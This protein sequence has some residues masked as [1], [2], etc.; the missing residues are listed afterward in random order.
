[1]AIPELGKAAAQARAVQDQPIPPE[2][3]AIIEVDTAFLVYRLPTG[4]VVANTDINAPI[5]P[6]RTAHSHDII[7][8]SHSVIG[9][10]ETMARAPYIGRAVVAEQMQMAQQIQAQRQQAAAMSALAGQQREGGR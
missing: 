5:V 7:G 8:M 10:V 1:M 3:S 2:E 6:A 9:D 4:E